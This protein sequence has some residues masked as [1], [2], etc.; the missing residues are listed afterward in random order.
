MPELR[1]L[2]IPMMNSKIPDTLPKDKGRD[3]VSDWSFIV[4]EEKLRFKSLI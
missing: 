2:D 3:Y 1:Q 4:P